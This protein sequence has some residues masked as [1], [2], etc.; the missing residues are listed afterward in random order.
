MIDFV[1]EGA[2]KLMLGF[3]KYKDESSKAVTDAVNE[4]SLAVES[5]AKN[6][7]A[8]NLGSN[9][10]TVHGGAGLLG[11]IYKHKVN[12]FEKQ[13]GTNQNYAPYIEFG[14]GDLVFTNFDFDANARQVASQ[15]R[16]KGIRKVNIRGDSFL[17]WAAVNQQPKL[18][19]RIENNLNKIN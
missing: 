17:N 6:R 10:H 14:T 8:G 16:G 7:L 9:R 3:E 2:Y 15:Y 1:L 11:S 5:D 13:V 12:D 4:T 19:E 18:I